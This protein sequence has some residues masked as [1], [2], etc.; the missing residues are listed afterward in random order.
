MQQASAKLMES[1]VHDLLDYAQIKAGKF[2]KNLV[3]FDIRNTIE[4]VKSI[5]QQKADAKKITLDYKISLEENLIFHDE[6]RISQILLN[7]YSNAVKFTE[8]G[9]VCIRLSIDDEYL[10]VHVQDTGAGISQENQQKLFK[11][12]G[13]IQETSAQNTSGIGLGLVIS[14]HLVEQYEGKIWVQSEVGVGSTFS[15]KL[16]LIEN[17]N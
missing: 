3:L 12:F 9:N 6:Q 14:K 5:L 7:L 17:E 13:L 16:K 11:L 4:E 15:F 8:K 1:L 2:R 10:T